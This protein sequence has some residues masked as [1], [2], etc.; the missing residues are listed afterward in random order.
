MPVQSR[1]HKLWCP[2]SVFAISQGEFPAMLDYSFC[3]HCSNICWSLTCWTVCSMSRSWDG[4]VRGGFAAG[5]LVAGLCCPLPVKLRTPPLQ[6]YLQGCVR[7]LAIAGAHPD[8]HPKQKIGSSC[9]RLPAIAGAHPDMHCK[10]KKRHPQRAPWL[11][12]GSAGWLPCS[13]PV[14]SILLL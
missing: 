14:C 12:R 6:P 1:A 7:P 9:V 2:Q 3:H 10:T 8:M 11:A 13:S 4:P 5:D